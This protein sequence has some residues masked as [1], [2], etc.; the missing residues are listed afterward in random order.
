MKGSFYPRGIVSPR[1]R[2]TGLERKVSMVCVGN[3]EVRSQDC[4][5]ASS[6]LISE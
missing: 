1:M 4:L 3:K 5:C 2:T 6:E